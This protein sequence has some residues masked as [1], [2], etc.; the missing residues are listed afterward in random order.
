MSVTLQAL[1]QEHRVKIYLEK[2][3]EYLGRLGYT[4]HGVRHATLTAN[5][6]YNVLSHLGHG[7]RKPEI[8]A[9]AGYLHDIGNAINR[10]AH[11]QIGAVFAHQILSDMGMPLE[12]VLLVCSAI[13]THEDDESDPVSDIAAALILADKSDVHRS[14]VRNPNMITF[15]IHDRVNYA[16]QHS[17]LKVDNQH[18]NISLS[19]KIDTKISKVMEYFEIFLSRMISCKRAAKFLGC[20][21]ELLINEVKLL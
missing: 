9:I 20:S 8:A 19:L 2:T 15:D 3:D 6:C 5:I 21:F 7:G 4:E 14:R 13:G 1:K 10:E 16:A 12:E 18:K 11:G 17:F